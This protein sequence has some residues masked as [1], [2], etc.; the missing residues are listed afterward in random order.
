ML[1][2]RAR[3]VQQ[4]GHPPMTD[5]TLDDTR[6]TDIAHAPTTGPRRRQCT[7]PHR[8]PGSRAVT[9]RRT[10]LRPRRRTRRPRRPLP[11]HRTQHRTRR[12][13]RRSRPDPTRHRPREPLTCVVALS[14]TPATS[15]TRPSHRAHP[16]PPTTC[17]LRAGAHK[18]RAPAQTTILRPPDAPSVSRLGPP[19]PPSL[20]MPNSHTKPPGAPKYAE[21]RIGTLGRCPPALD[22]HCPSGN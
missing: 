4:E 1:A 8:V 13:T 19:R 14:I 10:R 12:T 18:H 15:Q 17:T 7:R 11:R 20:F 6:L 16:H 22:G 9:A 3:S 21:F 2:D 5:I